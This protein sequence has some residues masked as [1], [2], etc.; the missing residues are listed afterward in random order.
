MRLSRGLIACTAL[1][2]LLSM[3]VD[4]ADCYCSS[5]EDCEE[6][7]SDPACSSIFLTDDLRNNTGTCIDD[8]ENFSNKIFDCQSHIINGDDA[9]TDYG[10]YLYGKNNNTIRDCTVTDFYYG[11]Y[12]RDSSS[13]TIADN[14]V[15]SNTQEG[16]RLYSDSFYNTITNNTVNYNLIYGIEL[17]GDGGYNTV[18]ENIV[19][20]QYNGIGVTGSSNNNITD[21]LANNNSNRGFYI[22][23]SYNSTFFNNTVNLSGY[24]FYLQGGAENTLLNNNVT[25]TFYAGIRLDSSSSNNTLTNNTVDYNDGHGLYVHDN[26]STGNTL[27][28]NSFCN[29]NQAAGAYYDIYD[30]DSTTGDDN[31]CNSAFSYNDTGAAGCTYYCYMNSYVELKT[32]WNLISLALIL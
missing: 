13:N 4:A 32:G 5:C 15:N 28:H 1:L 9:G 16:I 19:S 30:S 20:D 17:D 24:G 14:T 6:K 11:V 12:L 23:S 22:V 26:A 10:I 27:N 21:N 3:T 18:T 31:T 25:A 8:P 7:I 2:M 29:N